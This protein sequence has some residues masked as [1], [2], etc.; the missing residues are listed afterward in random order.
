[1][2]VIMGR[3][4]ESVPFDWVRRVW[5]AWTQSTKLVAGSKFIEIAAGD[6]GLVAY[7]ALIATMIRESTKN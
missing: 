7:A 4:D 6:H 2:T 5:E 3:K 1:V